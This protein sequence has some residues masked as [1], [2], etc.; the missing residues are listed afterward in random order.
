MSS[1]CLI[2]LHDSEEDYNESVATQLPDTFCLMDRRLIHLVGRDAIE[3]CD[4][5][6]SAKTHHSCETIPRVGYYLAVF[7]RKALYQVSFFCTV[8]EFREGVNN[9]LSE[10]FRFANTLQR[11][12]NEEFEVVFGIVSK[13]RNPLKLPFFSRVN[14]RNA[15]QRLRAF[16][17][18]GFGGKGSGHRGQQAATRSE[19]SRLAV[20]SGVQYGYRLLPESA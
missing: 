7:F 17:Y 20:R 18:K 11:P 16:G 13:S 2:S 10:G 8:P 1:I 5:Y 6:S 3:F 15:V 4:L 19:L 14:L 12:Q 9:Q